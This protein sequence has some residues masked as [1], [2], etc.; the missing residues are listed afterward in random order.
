MTEPVTFDN[1]LACPDGIIFTPTGEIWSRPFIDQTLG[2]RGGLK[3]SEWLARNQAVQQI[4]WAPGEPKIIEG[5][6]I[7]QDWID[8]PG[9][10]VF[11]LYKP[12][13]IN[14][15]DAAQAQ[16]WVDLVDKVYP[17][18]SGAIIAYLAFK[19]QFPGV[20]INHALILGGTTRIGKDT[21]IE[22]FRRAIGYDNAQTI[23][24]TELLGS[25]NDFFKCVAL[26]VSEARD[27]GEVNRYQLYEHM[28][29]FTASPP[30]TIRINPKHIRPFY[31]LNVLCIIYTTNHKDGL[32]IPFDDAR[33]YG[34]W[35]PCVKEDFEDGY[36]DRIWKWYET[37]GFAH[38]AAYLHSYDLSLFNPK[39]PPVRT[40]ALRDMIDAG[41]APENSE[42]ADLLDSIGNPPAVTINMLL[43]RAEEDF[44][45]WL[46]DRKNRKLIGRRLAECDYTPVRNP[47]DKRDGQ[48][49]INHQRVVV[50][51]LRS[52]SER[53]RLAAAAKVADTI[54]GDA[55]GDS[56]NIVDFPQPL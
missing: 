49:R 9:A 47:D 5:K 37:G 16:P 18:A 46:R 41:R 21:I 32:Y 53:E 13:P 39:V 4:T 42:M 40:E 20:K 33:H 51:A 17:D 45:Y 27:Q 7:D 48:W 15:G 2:R 38:V 34:A 11:N 25:F 6:L 23:A 44:G 31:I 52:L 43:I 35:S 12:P 24:P 26:I 1:T 10:R 19:A 22:P 14:G 30:M 50:Y 55:G 28:K 56:G 54:V 36:F 8:H 29:Q 3:A